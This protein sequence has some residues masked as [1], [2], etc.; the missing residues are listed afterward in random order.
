MGEGGGPHPK[1]SSKTG[2]VCGLY[3]VMTHHHPPETRSNCF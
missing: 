1:Y 2:R 3:E